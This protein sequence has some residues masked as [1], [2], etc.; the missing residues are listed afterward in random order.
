MTVGEL[1][2]FTAFRGAKLAVTN[3]DMTELA[4]SFDDELVD[5]VSIQSET[6]LIKCG[7][8]M[9]F[10]K[11]FLNVRCTVRRAENDTITGS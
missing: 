6:E 11:T 1:L 10:P 3:A 9:C 2:K 8:I 7:G 4:I 5:I